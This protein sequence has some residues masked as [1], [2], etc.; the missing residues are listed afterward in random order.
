MDRPLGQ[1]AVKIFDN[2]NC[3]NQCRTIDP[4]T[5]EVAQMKLV[6][7]ILTVLIL[8]MSAF[9]FAVAIMT[10]STHRNWKQAADTLQIEY[11]TLNAKLQQAKTGTIQKE[12]SI[13]AEKVARAQQLAQLESQLTAQQIEVDDLSK[14]L[15]DETILSKERLARMEQAEARAA[16]LD[17]QNK[18]LTERNVE[19]NKEVA[20]SYEKL[21]DLT[22]TT[23]ELNT[24]IE[25]IEKL[26]QDM[27]A[28]L[29]KWNKV[30]TL[31]GFDENELTNDIVPLVNAVVVKST[32][33]LFA[34]AAGSDDG[35]R[36]GHILDIYRAE[37]FVGR[38]VVREV[39]HDLAVLET[40]RE[41]MQASVKE[42]D[43]V[44]SKF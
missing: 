13:I 24:R 3:S 34:V 40:V 7:N 1:P 38:G 4:E 26:N 42:G 12:Q 21:T 8:L 43:N 39:Q 32:G 29:A 14:S 16:Q 6:G 17:R 15:N 37:T 30:G 18:G 9:F 33:P 36:K 35:L 11:D 25:E 44:T 2:D 19:L 22:N 31:K 28:K 20:T 10:V 23:F 27:S 5:P 41:F